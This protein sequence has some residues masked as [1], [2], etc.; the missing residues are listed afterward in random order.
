MLKVYVFTSW[1]INKDYI[2]QTSCENRNNPISDCAGSCQLV[3][4][5]ENTEPSDKPFT[6][7]TGVEK[8]E[9]SHYTTTNTQHSVLNDTC[10][11]STIHFSRNERLVKAEIAFSFFHPPE[12]LV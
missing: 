5:L 11:T 3:K 10:C 8:I 4:Q 9:L 1:Q 2:A 12:P 7:P 6:P